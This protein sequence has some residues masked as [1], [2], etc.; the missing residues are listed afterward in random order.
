MFNS[1]WYDTLNKPLLN[2]PAWI[3]SPVWIILYT[4]LLISLILYTTKTTYKNKLYGYILFVSQL[5]LNLAWSPIFFGMK[6]IGLALGVVILMDILTLLNIIY[7]CRV[8]KTSGLILIP[9]F[10]WI[11]F[12]TYLNAAF[13]VLN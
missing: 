11:L 5:V 9:Y 6:N 1:V 12:A 13:W 2:P 4:T 10:L 3:F 7:F 8:S